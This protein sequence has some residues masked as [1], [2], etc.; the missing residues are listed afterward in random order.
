MNRKLL[1]IYTFVFLLI[2]V[3]LYL[4]R[5]SYNDMKIYIHDV[6]RVNRVINRLERL[7]ALVQ[8][9]INNESMGQTHQQ[10]RDLFIAPAEAYDSILVLAENIKDL[11][12]Y[13]EQR[14][15][16]DSVKWLVKGYQGLHEMSDST[17]TES[18]REEYRRKINSIIQQS[19]TV[20]NSKL[21]ERKRNLN[22]STALL[23][24]WLVWMLICAGSLIT[25]ATFYSFNFLEQRRKAEGFSRTLLETTNNGIVSFVPV[26]EEYVTIDYKITY[27]N[28]AALKL[29]RITNWKSKTLSQVVSKTIFDDLFA[30]FEEVITTGVSKTMEGYLEYKHERNWLQ[31]TIAPLDYGILVSIYNLNP[32]MSY[33]QRLTYKINQLE[34]TNEELQ[35]YAYVTSHDLQEPLRKIQMFSDIG[36]NLPVEDGAEKKNAF[37]LKILATAN[38]MRD[39]IQTLL[40]FTR[41]TDRPSEW[42][43]VDLAKVV[44]ETLN[45][46]QEIIRE[47]K[48][49]IN[50]SSLPVIQGSEFH[51]KLLFTN[52][53]LNAL[54][55]SKPDTT[56]R[57][58]IRERKIAPLEYKR[59]PG[60]DQML[61]YTRISIQ[62]NGVGFPAG[63]RE[64][65]FTIFQRLH[66]KENTP[67]SGIGLAICRKIVHQH[68][69]LIYARGK[70]NRG[71]TFRIFLPLEQ[72]REEISE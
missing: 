58:D 48:A 40:N 47:K 66:N 3:M 45:E 38:H 62:D 33:Q 10:S 18:R 1:V 54:N 23:D 56:P 30:A 35:Q 63:L 49:E 19:F 51:L 2:G 42:K 11:A 70:E 15:R 64:K 71:A 43:K 60:L 55:Y 37:F 34:I 8:F 67:G 61:T 53:I 4:Y 28:E 52:L 50:V 59:F 6:N 36:L 39:L 69:G 14:L 13:Q 12:M 16:I 22:D 17:L 27:C 7:D 31:A 20:A 32:M 68:H 29:L 41:S 25:L 9:W 46:L 21:E 57:I 72:P 65:I 24:K 26:R 5:S 44:A